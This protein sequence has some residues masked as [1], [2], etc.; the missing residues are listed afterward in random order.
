MTR[1]TATGPRCDGSPYYGT[2]CRHD[3]RWLVRV[4]ERTTDGQ[5]ACSPHLGAA[6]EAM[7]GAEGRQAVL[8]V[9]KVTE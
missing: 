5:L 9:R 1:A 7:L 4:G 3:A 6:C 8:T 2:S